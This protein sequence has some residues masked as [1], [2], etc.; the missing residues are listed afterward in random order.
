M[1]S[2]RNSPSGNN[3]DGHNRSVIESLHRI[4][5]ANRLNSR[6]V[7]RELGLSASQLRLLE[8]L[9]SAP[10]SSMQQVSDLTHTDQSSV[11]VAVR[12]LVDRGL[13]KSAMSKND[14]RR[15]E[16]SLTARGKAVLFTTARK[17]HD[18][19]ARALRKLKPSDVRTLSRLLLLFVDSIDQ[20]DHKS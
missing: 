4:V 9:E 19:V 13:I 16:L 2:H 8:K 6:R 1:A 11:S 14:G 5:Q 18:C 7:E 20:E 3:S 15:Q 10:L 12:K 17:E